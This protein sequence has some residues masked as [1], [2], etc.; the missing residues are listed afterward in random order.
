MCCILTA[1]KVAVSQEMTDAG[2]PGVSRGSPEPAGKA[3]RNHLKSLLPAW[4]GRRLPGTRIAGCGSKRRFEMKTRSRAKFVLV[5][6][7]AA[8][9]GPFAGVLQAFAL[10][11]GDGPIIPH[12]TA[13]GPPLVRLTGTFCTPGEKGCNP[14]SL[15][16]FTLRIDNKNVLFKVSRAESLTGDRTGMQLLQDITGNKLYLRGADKTL[17]PLKDP[18]LIGKRV[19]I[20]GNLFVN[21][22]ILDVT[23]EGTESVNAG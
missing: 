15:R 10:G 5:V 2:R 7:C 20:Q 1:E 11:D 16:D 6:L 21:N 18:D 13:I 8:A 22:G 4:P 9:L 12:V 19:Y 14:E 23:A 3:K 17:R